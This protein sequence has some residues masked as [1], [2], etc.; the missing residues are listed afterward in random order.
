MIPFW[1]RTRLLWFPC[2]S[3]FRGIQH[4]CNF[5]TCKWNRKRQIKLWFVRFPM[6]YQ[7]IKIKKLSKTSFDLDQGRM[8]WRNCRSTGWAVLSECRQLD[9]HKCNFHCM[10]WKFSQP[11]LLHNIKGAYQKW[12]VYSSSSLFFL[13]LDYLSSFL[14]L[15][16]YYSRW[17]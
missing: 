1:S 11:Y 14:F 7:T 9:T 8:K 4:R 12:P 15:I 2:L 3:F 17:K 5:K 13:E 6:L 10:W 16:V